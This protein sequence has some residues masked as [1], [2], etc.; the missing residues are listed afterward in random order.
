M[1]TLSELW[2]LDI[3]QF[4]GE[5]SFLDCCRAPRE[6]L[7]A[8]ALA[9][10]LMMRATGFVVRNGVRGED[11]FEELAMTRA[12]FD[13]LELERAER[14]LLERMVNALHPL[15]GSALADGMLTL[16]WRAQRYGFT[17]SA[18][19]LAEFGY[20]SALA[21]GDDFAARSAS[22]ALARM[23]TLDECP[24]A[25]RR[26]TGRAFVHARRLERRRA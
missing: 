2:S 1:L 25:A 19:S 17:G 5:R 8:S 13:A 14:S 20:D 4:S 21:G 16:C 7:Q 26:W 18:R 23:A 6:S 15:D 12:Y 10:T 24:R 11:M 22:L 3:E 9:W